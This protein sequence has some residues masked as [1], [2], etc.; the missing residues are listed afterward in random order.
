MLSREIPAVLG[1]N[2]MKRSSMDFMPADMPSSDDESVYMDVGI[3]GDTF[4]TG[5]LSRRMYGAMMKV[6]SAKFPS[7]VPDDLV[8]VY[9]L[10]AMD[11]TAKE[12][13]KV[14]MDSNGY[15]LNLGDDEAMQ[16]EGAWGQVAGVSLLD[17]AG[18]AIRGE[19]GSDRYETFTDAIARGGVGA[20][21]PLQLRRTGGPLEEEGDGPRGPPGEPRP[22][23]DAPEAGQG[24]GPP[25]PRRGHHEPRDAQK[26]L[27]AARQRRPDGGLGRVVG[28]PRRGR[29]GVRRHRTG[30]A[31]PGGEERRRDR[32]RRDAPPRDGRAGEPRL[33]HRGPGRRRRRDGGRRGHGEDVADDRGV[34]REGR[35]GRRGRG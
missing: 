19:D 28:V 8:E 34:L 26:G 21:R 23:R 35:R 14:A 5:D 10:Y 2:W 11:A 1:G 32:G 9:L 3:G 6:A 13:V 33:P 25:A 22:G 12:A 20:R 27:R 31:A 17:G 15:A 18:N 4:G 16:D 29:E 7:G 30:G 24:A